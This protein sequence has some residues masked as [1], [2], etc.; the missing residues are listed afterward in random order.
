MTR[1]LKISS[2]F[3]KNKWKKHDESPKLTISG[4][5]FEEAGF[6]IGEQIQIQ[7]LNNQIII[8]KL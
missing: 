5:W 6:C 1:K 7:V 4:K 2:I 8:Q 3:R